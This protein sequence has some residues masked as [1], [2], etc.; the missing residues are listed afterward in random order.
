MFVTKVCN[1]SVDFRLILKAWKRVHFAL[2][3][4]SLIFRPRISRCSRVS[5][6]IVGRKAVGCAKKYHIYRWGSYHH[7]LEV[8]TFPCVTSFF[9]RCHEVERDNEVQMRTYIENKMTEALVRKCYKCS[10]PYVKVVSGHP[11]LGLHN[12]SGSFIYKSLF[13]GRV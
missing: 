1:V 6:R 10:K 9:F 7:Q 2:L 8:P 11:S 5:I 3:R 12:C 4:R 13:A